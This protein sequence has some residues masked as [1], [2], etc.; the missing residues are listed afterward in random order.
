MII[1]LDTSVVYTETC[2]D[3]PSHCLFHIIINDFNFCCTFLLV[4]YYHANLA[5]F[6]LLSRP[7]MGLGPSSLSLRKNLC[8]PSLPLNHCSIYLRISQGPLL[9]MGLVGSLKEYFFIDLPFFRMD[10]D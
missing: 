9:T 10:I 7:I 3:G 4:P 5:T 8:S 2:K 1:T 6:L